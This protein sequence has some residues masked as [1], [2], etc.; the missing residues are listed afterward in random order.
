MFQKGLASFK[1]CYIR[2]DS[3]CIQNSVFLLKKS[4]NMKHFIK[5][6]FFKELK[7]VINALFAN[8]FL[9]LS[10]DLRKDK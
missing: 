8:K 10:F 2:K 6:S 4:S 5:L 3:Y 1:F 7:K 9:K